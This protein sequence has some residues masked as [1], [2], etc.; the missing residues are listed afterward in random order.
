[1]YNVNGRTGDV[2]F[3]NAVY[4]LLLEQ[5][6][7]TRDL[8]KLTQQKLHREIATQKIAQ[9]I[10][11]KKL[12]GFVALDED[13][14]NYLTEAGEQEAQKVADI[15]ANMSEEELN[16]VPKQTLIY[17]ETNTE[18]SIPQIFERLSSIRDDIS[19]IGISKVSFDEFTKFIAVK[20]AIDNLIGA[21][22]EEQTEEQQ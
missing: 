3:A 19:K 13:K 16:R 2:V 14:N 9:F 7:N 8:R 10:Y 6:L 15:V 12:L 4:Q 17:S 5:H 18:V 21:K 22:P 11:N 20:E 1:M